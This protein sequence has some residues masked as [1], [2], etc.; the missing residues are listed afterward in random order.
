MTTHATRARTAKRT[1]LAT[2]AALAVAATALAPTAAANAD[3]AEGARF[4]DAG[5][6]GL[7]AAE[8]A[9]IYGEHE[10]DTMDD[11]CG[12][13]SGKAFETVAGQYGAGD[14]GTQL[15]R[16]GEHTYVKIDVGYI[17]TQCAGEAPVLP[18]FIFPAGTEGDVD[19]EH[20]IF[21]SIYDMSAGDV[22]Y[23]STPMYGSTG[24]NGGTVVQR[25]D[26]AAKKVVPWT[27]KRGQVLSLLLPMKS[28]RVLKGAATQPPTCD[29]RESG[30]A[31]CPVAQSGD[32]LQVVVSGSPGYSTNLI[33]YVGMFVQKA[34]SALSLKLADSTIR[35]TQYGRLGITVK[36]DAR[37]TGTLVI[38]DGSRTIKK[39]TLK[40]T[41]KNK[42]V[43]TLPRLRAGTHKLT[44][45]YAGNSNAEAAPS[46]SI[47]LKVSR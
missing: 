44:V 11:P 26:T 47:T 32:H 9:W 4:I 43:V 40:S 7:A 17:G 3:E 14:D 25:Y 34:T 10:W 18:E 16:V 46:K 33:P 41:A 36:S 27:L 8:S 37:A 22:N 30:T 28:T 15:P 6:P 12:G 1:A 21:W 45:S 38:K 5:V 24:R 39:V 23:Q 13:P 42:V 2:M 19:A 20:G 31:P 29:W 35:S